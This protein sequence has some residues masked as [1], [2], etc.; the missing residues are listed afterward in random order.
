VLWACLALALP[1]PVAAQI[2]PP[3]PYPPLEIIPSISLSERYND[4][5][6]QRSHNKIDEWRTTISPSLDLGLST[7][8][9]RSDLHYTLGVF[10]STAL[11]N[12]PYIQHFLNGS[13]K[14]SLTERFSFLVTEAFVVSDDPGIVN[15]QGVD[16]QVKLT[17][18]DVSGSLLYQGDQHSGWLKYTNTNIDRE[19]FS[20]TGSAPVSTDVSSSFKNHLNIVGA[21]GKWQVG[22]V[23]TV[24][25]SETVTFGDF[26]Q[27]GPSVTSSTATSFV[28]YETSVAAEREFPG[29]TRGGVSTTW[30]LRDPDVGQNVN[31]VRPSITVTRPITASVSA[32]ASFGYDFAFGGVDTSEPSGSLTLTYLGNA[33]TAN[34]TLAQGMYETFTNSQNIGLTRRREVTA[35]VSYKPTDRV[36][37]STRASAVQTKFFEPDVAFSQGIV[38][39][40]TSP[41]PTSTFY[42]FEAAI[43]VVLTRI[44]SASLSYVYWRRDIADSS[45]ALQAAST[46]ALQDFS[47][48]AVT[49]QLRARYE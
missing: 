45:A 22:P 49:L 33:V 38:L 48:N 3:A 43:N 18:N 15:P 25:G 27:S 44:F 37:L 17:R 36:T 5:Y 7:S 9:T 4:N 30:S 42:T 39:P 35:G 10:H 40:T 46:F 1:A 2:V 19:F 23:T 29:D 6:F 28:V 13:S 32:T 16:N 31:L 24:T 21:G 47:S 11:D 14:I 34:L 12:N 41:R 26:S 8:K 20:V